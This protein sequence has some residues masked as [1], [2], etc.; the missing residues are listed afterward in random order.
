VPTE[1][2]V[3][4]LVSERL[5][6][7]EIAGQIEHVETGSRATVTSPREIVEAARRLGHPALSAPHSSSGGPES[8]PAPPLG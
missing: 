5:A 6:A 1:T 2:F 4:R 3:L 8:T 7:G